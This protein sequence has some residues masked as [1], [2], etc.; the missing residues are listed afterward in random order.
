MPSVVDPLTAEATRYARFTMKQSV[1]ISLVPPPPPTARLASAPAS[2]EWQT[3][4]C[5]AA[6]GRVTV[7]GFRASSSPPFPEDLPRLR[8][9][10]RGGTGSGKNFG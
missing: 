6:F 8:H 7:A 5:P 1:S 3:S 9:R 2:S 4:R 10:P